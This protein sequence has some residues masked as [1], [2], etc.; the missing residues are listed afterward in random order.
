MED[1]QMLFGKYEACSTC[2]RGVF[3]FHLRQ[4]E[5]LLYDDLMC[6]SDCCPLWS[7]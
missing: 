4:V 6:P 3:L 5:C 7:D 1:R 2:G